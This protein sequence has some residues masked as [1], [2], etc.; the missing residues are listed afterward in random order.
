M[1]N[2]RSEN[3]ILSVSKLGVRRSER[4]LFRD[5]TFQLSVGEILQVVGRNGAGKTSL[6]RTLCGLLSNIE[7]NIQWHERH[8]NSELNANLDAQLPLFVGHLPAVKMEL[9]VFE[10]L[11]Y[12]PLNGTFADSNQISEAI[13]EVGLTEY[14]YTA[15]RYLSAG[16]IRRVALARLLLT[17]SNCWILDEPFTSLDVGGCQWLEEKMQEFAKQGG[18]VIITSHQEVHLTPEP[19][20]LELKA[21]DEQAC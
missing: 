2:T 11:K 4:W 13:D 9:S 8:A 5:L 3:T 10:N 18:S 12:H 16:Q 7:G 17:K 14:T 6:L 15:T 19:T 21:M 20:V 1:M